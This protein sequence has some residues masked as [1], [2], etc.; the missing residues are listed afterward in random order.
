MCDGREMED[1]GAEGVPSWLEF[2]GVNGWS[3]PEIELSKV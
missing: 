1:A 2:E 3:L